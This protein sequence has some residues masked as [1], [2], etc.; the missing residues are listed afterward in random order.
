M[1][2]DNHGGTVVLAEATQSRNTLLAN[3]QHA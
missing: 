3:P 2:N 1:E